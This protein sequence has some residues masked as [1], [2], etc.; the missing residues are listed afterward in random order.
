MKDRT[1]VIMAVVIVLA[2][3]GRILP[4]PENFAPITAIALFSAATLT[5]RRLALIT[6]LIAYYVSD[7]AIEIMHQRGL[8]TPWGFYASMWV[9]YGAILTV[10]AFGLTLRGRKSPVA[11]FGATIAA[12]CFYFVVTNLGVWAFDG[13]YPHTLEGLEKCYVLAL[14]FFRRALLGDAV[15]VTALFGS[16]ALVERW[17]PAVEASS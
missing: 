15:Y 8:M 10:A 5:D 17:K 13:E 6:P 9:T 16:L 7:V 1:L 11:I 3:L 14:P 2:I 12:S 4:H